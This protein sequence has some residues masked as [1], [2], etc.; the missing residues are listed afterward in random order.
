MSRKIVVLDPAGGFAGGTGSTIA[1][2]A[3][4]GKAGATAGKATFSFL[5]PATVGAKAADARAGLGFDTA[6]LSFRSTDIRLVGKEGAWAQF[7]GSGSVNGKAGYLFFMATRAGAVAGNG[8]PGRFGLKIWH[9]DPATNA[10]VVDYDNRR[11]ADD[12]SS[13]ALVEGKIAVQ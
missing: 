12:A 9:T 5:A 7:A 6:G 8:E 4:P 3:S 2:S 10:E 1:A 11:A 13:H